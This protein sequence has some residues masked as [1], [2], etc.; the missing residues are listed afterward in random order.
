MPH[1]EDAGSGAAPMASSHAPWRHPLRAHPIRNFVCDGGVIF[2]SYR[3]EAVT[4]RTTAT[5][6]RHDLCAELQRH[7]SQL[8]ALGL[9]RPV[10][11]VD[12]ESPNCTA[13]DLARVE[14][15]PRRE[16]GLLAARM[17]GCGPDPKRIG[18][19]QSYEKATGRI[20]ELRQQLVAKSV[21]EGPDDE[22]F[23][24]M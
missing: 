9:Q 21:A 5:E 14:Q 13:I 4:Q 20:A 11:A 1:G 19:A 8:K 16:L 12:A 22:V 7:E 24:A 17:P 2:G 3:A 18:A 10:A 15:M 6:S 23:A